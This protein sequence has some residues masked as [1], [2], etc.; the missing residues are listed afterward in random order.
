MV[1]KVSHT[2]MF[3]MLTEYSELTASHSDA[4]ANH[5]CH[6][7]QGTS[8]SLSGFTF[9]TIS[10]VCSEESN[11]HSDAIVIHAQ[12]VLVTSRS[13]SGLSSAKWN[14]N[15]N[16]KKVVEKSGIRNGKR[17]CNMLMT[18]TVMHFC[19]ANSL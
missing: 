9:Q 14:A 18:S 3:K 16:I 15:K 5:V 17:D 6:V 4:I 7:Y 8:G 1:S 2:K 10:G 11:S 13:I 12:G 19:I